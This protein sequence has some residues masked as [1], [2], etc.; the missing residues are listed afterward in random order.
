MASVSCGLNRLALF[1]TIAAS[2]PNRPLE[3]I[4]AS[5]QLAAYAAIALRPLATPLA[6][7]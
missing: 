1:S 3:N 6:A 2:N 5:F 4:L 7:I